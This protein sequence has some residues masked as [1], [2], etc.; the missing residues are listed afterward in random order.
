[1]KFVFAVLF[2]LIFAQTATA[3]AGV[4]PDTNLLHCT[5]TFVNY[6]GYPITH[7]AVWKD[8]MTFINFTDNLFTQNI[9]DPTGLVTICNALEQLKGCVAPYD[10]FTPFAFLRRQSSAVDAFI[11]SGLLQEYN[12]RC[13]AG[14]YT[15]LR[16]N[17]P[18]VQR[19]VAG[20]SNQ[21][22]G[23]LTTYIANLQHD[24]QNACTHVGNYMTCVSAIFNQS[25]CGFAGSTDHWWACESAYQLTQ[26]GFPSCKVSCANGGPAGLKAFMEENTK[27]EGGKFWLKPHPVFKSFN[28]IWKL[29]ENDWMVN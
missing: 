17:F 24:M 13:G 5:D 25:A 29:T 2:A 9:G 8:Y 7:N 16:E 23:C 22:S 12:F 11:F 27:I 15:I 26:P 4:C 10:C 6:I 3:Q 14:L 18:C 28:G 20:H 21:L 1:M 19:V